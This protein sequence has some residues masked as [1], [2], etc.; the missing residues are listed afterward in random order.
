[1]LLF[2]YNNYDW[3]L[4]FVVLYNTHW[5]YKNFNEWSEIVFFHQSDIYKIIF[6]ISG[7]NNNNN[8]NTTLFVPN[9]LQLK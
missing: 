2:Y 1:M 5:D 4:I 7:H 8:N 3:V 6:E 9:I